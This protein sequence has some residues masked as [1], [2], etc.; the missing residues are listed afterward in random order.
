[1]GP[2]DLLKPVI[3]GQR[4]AWQTDYF[5]YYEQDGVVSKPVFAL[6]A[7]QHQRW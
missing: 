6:P 2:T 4:Q 5:R 7:T 1:M 3:E